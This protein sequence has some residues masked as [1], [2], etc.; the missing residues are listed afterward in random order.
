MLL[1]I[2]EAFVL[3]RLQSFWIKKCRF[4]ALDHEYV[5]SDRKTDFILSRVKFKLELDS[6]V[7]IIQTVIISGPTQSKA[8]LC[9]V[10]TG[11]ATDLF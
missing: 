1:H 5:S 11:P 10:W 8:S 4:A 3:L 2:A 7:Q 6:D 9:I